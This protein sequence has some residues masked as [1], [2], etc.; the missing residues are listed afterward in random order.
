ML[1]AFFA[2]RPVHGVYVTILRTPDA[3]NTDVSAEKGRLQ[4]HNGSSE[5]RTSPAEFYCARSLPIEIDS[6]NTN[7]DVGAHPWKRRIQIGVKDELP[8]L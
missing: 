7:L 1:D 5:A 4:L 3:R 8:R 6:P 2:A